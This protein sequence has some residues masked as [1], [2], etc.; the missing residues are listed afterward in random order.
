MILTVPNQKTSTEIMMKAENAFRAL[1]QRIDLGFWQLP[2]RNE[3][4]LASEKFAQ[5]IRGYAK[6]M[7]VI[8]LGGSFSGGRCLVESLGDKS[9]VDFLFNTDPQTVEATFKQCEKYADCHYLIISKSGNTLEIVCLLEILLKK[10]KSQNRDFKKAISVITE[11]KSSPLFDWV[12]ANKIQYLAHPQDVGGRFSVFTPVGLV[13]AAFSGVS[14]AEL[15]T[16]AQ[17]AFADKSLITQLAAYYLESFQRE[18][19]I[20]AFWSYID[21]LAAFS[22]WLIQL[23]AESLAKKKT[24]QGREAPRV[25]TPVTYL[26]TCDQ[27]SVLQQLMEGAKDKSIC[28]LRSQKLAESGESFTGTQWAGF[29]Y[30]KDKNLGQVFA[31]QSQATEE[32]LQSEGRSTLSIELSSVEPE[33]VGKLLM[34]FELLIG[35]LGEALD[36]NAFNQ[37]GVELGKKIT[38]EKLQKSFSL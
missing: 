4:W 30:L 26:G 8:G 7:L 28:F 1:L 11:E 36:I 25:S 12:V 16:G 21:Q 2:E 6:H 24:R 5:D 19:T 35:V 34:V 32:A 13:P 20:S 15:R 29:E 3:N 38:K 9:A 18:E 10:L 22:P 33:S 31:T 27:H 37:P 14:L 23:W 17:K